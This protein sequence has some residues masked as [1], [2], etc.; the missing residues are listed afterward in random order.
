MVGGVIGG[1]VGL[2]AGFKAGTVFAVGGGVLGYT[3]TSI[4]KNIQEE[5]VNSELEKLS[6]DP[7]DEHK[8]DG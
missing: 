1:P 7:K 4:I 8:V 2:L 6:D 5:A 3:A